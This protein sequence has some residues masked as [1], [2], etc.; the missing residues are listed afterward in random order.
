MINGLRIK[1][2]KLIKTQHNDA[3]KIIDIS[4]MDFMEN[5][6]DYLV[7]MKRIIE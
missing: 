4:E 5:R 7:I 2:K 1:C 3:I 6:K